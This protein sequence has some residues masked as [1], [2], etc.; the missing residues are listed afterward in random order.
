MVQVLARDGDD[1]RKLV[2]AVA[3]H[4]VDPPRGTAKLTSSPCGASPYSSISTFRSP[5]SFYRPFGLSIYSVRG[6]HGIFG[7]C[8]AASTQHPYHANSALNMAERVEYRGMLQMQKQ[9][10]SP[11]RTCVRAAIST[12]RAQ[13]PTHSYIS[14]RSSH[15]RD[16]PLAQYT[17][18][19]P[20]RLSPPASSAAQRRLALRPSYY[21]TSA[22]SW[23]LVWQ[24][25][26]TGTDGD[27]VERQLVV[28]VKEVPALGTA[29]IV[30]TIVEKA[31]AIGGGRCW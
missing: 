26:R 16:K 2:A 23:K 14:F 30:L 9:Q 15:V 22:K 21:V 12:R 19:P 7:R 10:H 17:F 27:G 18:A 29:A 25:L 6:K 1:A 28:L 24:L 13:C 8:G 5:P 4:V 3:G 11:Q 31:L 20:R